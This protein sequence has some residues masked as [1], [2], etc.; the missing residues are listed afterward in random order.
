MKTYKFDLTRVYRVTV[1][2]ENEDEARH[3]AE[4]FLGDPKDMSTEIRRKEHNFSIGE[5]KMLYNDA[6]ESREGH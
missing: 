5:I 6:V 3:Y 4:F 1:D 2:A